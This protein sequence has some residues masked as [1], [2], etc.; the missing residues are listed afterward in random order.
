MQ[1]R[2]FGDSDVDVSVISLDCGFAG[3]SWWERHSDE[4]ALRLMQH[5]YGQGISFFDIVDLHGSGRPEG[6][7]CQFLKCVPRGSVQIGSRFGQ[8]FSPQNMRSS[9]EASLRRLGVETI[10][11]YLAHHIRLPQFSDEL[12]AE[13]EKVKQVGKIRAWGISLGPTIGWREEGFEAMLKHNAQAVQTIF[14]LLEQNPG[15]ELG[16]L[17]MSQHAGILARGHDC[18]S[19]LKGSIEPGSVGQDENCKTFDFRKLQLVRKYADA[20]GMTLHQL[21]CKWLLQQTGLTSITA[22]LL[23]EQ[24]ITEA[25]ESVD[26]P[27]LTVQELAQIAADYANDW[28]LGEDAHPCDLASSVDPSGKVR[29]GYVPPPVLFA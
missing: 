15:K 12:F 7:L 6:V 23:G 16:E 27:D 5:A 1:R 8:D 11:V 21:A 29:S 14:N 20:H 3:Q 26:K 24:E 28:N 18:R 10:D 19:L 22:T 17:A 9:L 2:R 25:A 4:D 13:L